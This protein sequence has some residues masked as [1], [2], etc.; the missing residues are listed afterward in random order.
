MPS[1]VD[2]FQFEN[3]PETVPLDTSVPSMYMRTAP[4]ASRVYTTCFRAVVAEFAGLF[5]PVPLLPV[6][7]VRIRPSYVLPDWPRTAFRFVL[8]LGRPTI[9][10]GPVCV[11]LAGFTHASIV[12]WFVDVAALMIF[13]A[14][15]GERIVVEELIVSLPVPHVTAPADA[16]VRFS[17]VP[18]PETSRT[19]VPLP[20]SKVYN[21]WRLVTTRVAVFTV[22]LAES[23]VAMPYAFV[24]TQRNEE[25]LSP[26][27]VAGVVYEARVAPAITIPFFFH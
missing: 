18:T 20:S 23:L 24:T 11:V 14:D 5:S 16:I 6:E 7:E 12:I 4:D 21:A 19:V 10:A 17:A 27:T 3:V 15:D 22:N 8:L 25:P 2:V 13:V 9:C 26:A 1:R